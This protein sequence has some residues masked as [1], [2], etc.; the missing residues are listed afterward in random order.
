[1]FRN[2]LKMQ[3]CSIFFPVAVI[4]YEKLSLFLNIVCTTNT[5]AK[6]TTIKLKLFIRLGPI[7][8][9]LDPMNFT[10]YRKAKFFE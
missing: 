10:N 4:I 2:Q 7:V 1:M 9:Q 5:N 8:L 3:T 6:F